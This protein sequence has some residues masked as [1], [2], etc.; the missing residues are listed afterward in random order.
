MKWLTTL[1]ALLLSGPLLAQSTYQYWET[2]YDSLA[3]TLPRQ[4]TDTARLRVLV[5]LLDLI[6]LTELRRRRQALPQLEELLTLNQRLHQLNDVPYQQLR[7]GVRL[8]AQD[9]PAAGALAAMQ[10]AVFLFDEVHRPVP[11]LLIAMAPLFNQLRQEPARGVYFRQKL[12]FYQVRGNTENTAAC[13][14]ALG[15][16]Y[17]RKGDYNR[18]VSSLLRS[19][20]VFRKFDRIHYLNE[21]MA[22]G[23]IY[24][25]WGNPQKA[26]Q[27]LRLAMRLEDAY[28]VEGVR[29]FYT[30]EA[31]AKVYEQQG[32]YPAALRYAD[33]GL[34]AAH[35]D[36]A[37]QLSYTA[38]GLVRK[39]SVLLSRGQLA[40]ALPLLRQ[41][42]QIDDSL[43]LPMTGRVGDFELE[44]TWARYYA[45]R[46]NYAQAEKYW[47]RA[48]RRATAARLEVL[49][50][51]YLAA[52]SRFY[53]ARGQPAEAQRY[54][55]AYL[56]LA[57]ALNATQGA[58]RI[59]QYEGERTEQAHNA[60]LANM[61]QAEA[62]QALRLKQRNLLLGGALLVVLVVSGLGIF[63]YRQLQTNRRTL[64]QLRQA[65]NQLV[66]SEKW[67][68][69]GEL[70]AGIAHELQ[71][72]LNFMKNF[73][74]VSTKLVDGMPPA[75]P[76]SPLVPGLE[77]EIVAGLRQNLQEIS[78]HGLR[79]SA[80]IKNMLE[81][82]RSGTGQPVPTDLNALAEEAMRLAYHGFRTQDAQFTATLIPRFEA[83]LRPV[84]VLPQDLS[85][86][87]L[88][89]CTNALQA[90]R[91]QQQSSPADY[92]PEVCVSTAQRENEVE[93]RV[94]DN[95]TGM[96]ESVRQRIFE[97]FFTTK[98]T[99][100]GSGLG[101]S[102]SY[103]IVRKGHGGTITV[104]SE[105]GKGTEFV[106]VLPC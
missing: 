62:L 104:S 47:L 38:Y 65:Q 56:T 64:R 54:S 22:A 88:N 79:A 91:Q 74:E 5:H 29:R 58:F 50:P 60:Q 63:I 73:A 53:D 18:S 94:R 85:R 25:D 68:F 41:A 9:P 80:I 33:L 51:R 20:D 101:L 96:P 28:G 23:S 76:D 37:A 106:I 46:R 6:D 61:R 71:N 44:A 13:Y 102:L 66:Q 70:S 48:Y 87:L 105:V 45:A 15:G 7:V 12:A 92:A 14:L 83:R 40:P 16:Y 75:P 86:V 89:L 77:Q 10:Q 17:R 24:A 8:W 31:I 72:P 21:V 34:R 36:S 2:D 78:Q 69:V 49:Q 35:G 32:N 103:D 11:R 52:L 82:S 19:A 93:I 4:P 39:S 98:P 97:P 100:E 84:R 55:R 3:R 30:I 27:Y 59:A 57:D 43:H 95:G 81:H 99:G 42:Q 1:L 90:V 26:L 67:A